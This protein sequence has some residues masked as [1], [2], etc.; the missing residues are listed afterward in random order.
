MKAL[1]I[2][3]LFVWLFSVLYVH[4]EGPFVSNSLG[5]PVEIAQQ[6]GEGYFDRVWRF[7]QARWLSILVLGFVLPCSIGLLVCVFLRRR[8]PAY[9]A[10]FL[11]PLLLPVPVWWAWG[12]LCVSAVPRHYIKG[13]YANL[14]FLISI[15][16]A[17]MTARFAYYRQRTIKQVA[18]QVK[19]DQ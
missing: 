3:L 4:S 10:P 14:T 18:Q 2:S 11:L 7:I 15:C 8:H 16:L 9:Q 12:F 6:Y 17:I 13:H 5:G 19:A 1:T